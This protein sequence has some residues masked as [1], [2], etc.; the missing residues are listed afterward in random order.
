MK[1]SFLTA[2]R[3]GIGAFVIYLFGQTLH[4]LILL[5]AYGLN[6]IDWIVQVKKRVLISTTNNSEKKRSPLIPL[7]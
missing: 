5:L 4:R 6:T 7:G 1:T 2:C 3:L